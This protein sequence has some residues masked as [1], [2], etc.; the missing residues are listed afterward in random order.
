MAAI[1]DVQGE[2]PHQLDTDNREDTAHPLYTAETH[3][4]SQSSQYDLAATILPSHAQ[5]LDPT[6]SR[7][8]RRKIDF[9]FIPLMW[10]G[11]GFV[12]YD[13][14]FLPTPLVL[15]TIVETLFCTGYPRQR[16]SLRHD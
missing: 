9:F 8:V 2:K 13:K 3:A 11:Y 7:R 12:Y 5:I 14:V 16:R 4:E 6:L 1:H 10:V 15:A